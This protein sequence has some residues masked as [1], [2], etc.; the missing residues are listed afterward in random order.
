MSDDRDPADSFRLT[1]RVAIVTGAGSGI[2]AETARVLA[3]AGAHVVCADLDGERAAVT[4]KEISSAGRP[5]SSGPLDVTDAAAVDSLVR[6]VHREHGRLDVMANVAGIMV[7]QPALEVTEQ[8]LDLVLAVNLKGVFFGCQSAGRVM[9]PGASIINMASAIIDHPSPRRV[10][11]AISKA[12]VVQVTRSFAIE[13][14][15]RGIRVNAVAPGWTV[16]GLTKRHF[17]NDDGSIDEQ[18]RDQVVSGKAT[19]SPL[20]TVAQTTD[21]AL[22]VLY[23]ASDAARF[24]TGQVLRPSGGTV[25]G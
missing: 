19:T 14:G 11:Y 12:G 7:E 1:D 24:Y 25:F 2:G 3:G 23:L 8:E 20:G 5:A 6:A 21:A 17:S 22:A 9:P 18:R 15:E 10:S 4:A 16:T 13:L